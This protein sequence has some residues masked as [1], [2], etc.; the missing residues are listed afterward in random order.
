MTY[1]IA[2]DIQNEELAKTFYNKIIKSPENA[3]RLIV[4]Y[5][6][7][8]LF[9]F[10]GGMVVYNCNEY[11]LLVETDNSIKNYNIIIRQDKMENMIG[12]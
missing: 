10:A 1:P 12:K 11:D 4:K 5:L 7:E 3:T 2:D 6:G 8:T 9:P